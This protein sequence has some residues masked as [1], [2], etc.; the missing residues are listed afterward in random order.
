[1]IN[2]LVFVVMFFAVFGSRRVG[3]KTQN[4]KEKIKKEREETN[5]V[6]YFCKLFELFSH[7]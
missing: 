2:H 3:W 6:N 5:S 1:M 4:K 7:I